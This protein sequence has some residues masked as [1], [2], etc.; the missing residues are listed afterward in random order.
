DGLSRWVAL[1]GGR[2][3]RP[4][5]PRDCELVQ[6]GGP[7]AAPKFP[8][9]HVVG[10]A[11]FR[12]GSPLGAYVGAEGTRRPPILLANGV[13][14]FSRTALPDR[15]LIARTYGWVVPLRPSSVHDWDLP[16]LQARVDRADAELV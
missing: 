14:G 1:R 3:P 13:L 8:F 7:P 5:T 16:G 10:R 15:E 11:S 2:L 9:L 4:C 6:I 12:P